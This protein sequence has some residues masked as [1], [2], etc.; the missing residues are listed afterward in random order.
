MI[1]I[2]HTKF[3]EK[4]TLNVDD[5]RMSYFLHKFRNTYP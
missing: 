5:A 1:I 2:A 3:A 4:I